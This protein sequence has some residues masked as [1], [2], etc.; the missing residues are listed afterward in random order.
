MTKPFKFSDNDMFPFS[1]PACGERIEETIGRLKQ[2]QV[3]RCSHC[4]INAWFYPETLA[5]AVGEAE[6]AAN[7]FAGDIQLGKPRY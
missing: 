1:C 2:D 7:D 4:G 6:R 5:R 3:V